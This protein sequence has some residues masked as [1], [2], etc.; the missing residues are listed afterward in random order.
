MP[1]VSKMADRQHDSSGES[2][3]K[4]RLVICEDVKF[5]GEHFT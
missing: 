4:I 2:N 3:F 1:Y 5:C